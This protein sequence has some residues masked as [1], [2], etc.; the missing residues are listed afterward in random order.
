MELTYHSKQQV[1]PNVWEFSLT[2]ARDYQFIPGQYAHFW[3]PDR[4]LGYRTF[5]IT[6]HPTEQ[7]V[8][9]MTRFDQPLS[10]YKAAL[11]AL[12]TG[13]QLT[14]GE[15]MGDAVLP[16]LSSTPLVFV[17]QGLALASYLSILAECESSALSHLDVR[18]RSFHT[19][20][21]WVRRSEDDPLEKLIPRGVRN[22]TRVDLHYPGL[23]PL[24]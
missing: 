15:A 23:R 2:S 9:F 16:R 17:A 24:A 3:L 22:L 6:S 19:T 11:L 8:R 4:T 18:E 5:T 21:L 1:A 10:P 12:P 13:A 14:V 7:T 20:L